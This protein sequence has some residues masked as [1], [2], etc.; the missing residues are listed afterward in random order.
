[1][2]NQQQFKD[3]VK[4]ALLNKAEEASQSDNMFESIKYEIQ[5]NRSEKRFMLKEK[6]LPL[7]LNLKKSIITASCGIFIIAGSVLT[8]SPSIRASALQIIDK[9]V[10][11]YTSIRN[12]DKAPSKDTLKKDLG[13]AIKMPASLPGGYKLVDSNI[14]GHIDGSLP[15]EKQYDKKAA[16]AIY[17]KDKSQKSS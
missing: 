3:I 12:Y 14:T 17:S 1:M 15:P 4:A 2:S 8:F 10:N 5:S 16:G 6:F 9:N 11:G 7:N 13:Y